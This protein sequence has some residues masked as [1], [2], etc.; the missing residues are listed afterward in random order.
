MRLARGASSKFWPEVAAFSLLPAHCEAGAW[1]R[2]RNSGRKWR[3][4]RCFPRVVTLARGSV[5]ESLD[6]SGGPLAVSGASRRCRVER[7]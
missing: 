5:L 4:S 1:E 6:V 7:P 2:P 3:P